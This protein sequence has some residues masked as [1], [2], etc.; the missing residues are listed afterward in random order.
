MP[1]AYTYSHDK[2]LGDHH[3]GAAGREL[4]AEMRD[5]DMPPG[6]QVEHVATDDAT[7]ALILAWTD[8]SSVLRHTAVT[9]EFFSGHFTAQNGAE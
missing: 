1:S 4:P 3:A 7:G 2:G 6:T 8:K 9:P 5:L